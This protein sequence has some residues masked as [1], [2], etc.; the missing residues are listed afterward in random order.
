MLTMRAMAK[1]CGTLL[2]IVGILPV[3]ALDKAIDKKVYYYSSEQVKKTYGIDAN[4]KNS[5]TNGALGEILESRMKGGTY[6]VTT[7]RKEMSQDPEFHKTKTHIFYVLEGT[8]ILVTGGKTS[9]HATESEAAAKFVGQTVEGGQTW[10]LDKGSIIVVPAGV[11][12]W[13]KDIPAKPW[14]AFNIEL[15]E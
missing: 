15:F 12:H 3:R 1:V 7:R 5:S 14:I 11:V 4:R 10:K 8:A 6:K 9:G 13:F 2:L